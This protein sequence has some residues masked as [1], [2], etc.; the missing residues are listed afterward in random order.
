[1]AERKDLSYG[2][3]AEVRY[4]G[5]RLVGRVLGAT[6]ATSFSALRGGGKGRSYLIKPE[7]SCEADVQASSELMH[8]DVPVADLEW[9][10]VPP[11]PWILVPERMVTSPLTASMKA[12]FK[13]QGLCPHCGDPGFWKALAL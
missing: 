7:S 2:D 3:L 6:R 13:K 12:Y 8:Y 1:M 5:G 10:V 11:K 4:V 9:G